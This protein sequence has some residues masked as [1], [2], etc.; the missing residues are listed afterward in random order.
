MAMDFETAMTKVRTLASESEDNIG[1]LKQGILDLAPAVGIGPTALAEGLL[2]IES[3][4]FRGAA[5]MDILTMSAQASAVGL[6]DTSAVARA[7]TAAIN[8]YGIENLSA[9]QA[10]DVL[11]ATVDAGGAEASELAGELGRVVGIASQ[12][13]ISFQEVGAFIATYTRLGLSA[14]EATTGLSGVMNTILSPSKEARDALAGVGL[15]AQALR[16]A[17]QEQGLAGALAMLTDRLG[18]NAEATAAVFGNVRALAGVMG[19]AGSQ[20][21]TYSSILAQ[22]G[23]SAGILNERF[24][25]WRTTTAATWKEFTAQAQVAAIQIGERLA[26]AFSKVLQAAAP[27]LDAFIKLVEW[28]GQLPQ[29]VQTV[30]IGFLGLAAAIGPVAWAIGTIM[31]AGSGFVGLL[32]TIGIVGPVAGAGASVAAGGI[33][34]LWLALAPLAAPAAIVGGILAIGMAI[35]K[36]VDVMTSAETDKSVRDFALANFDASHGLPSMDMPRVDAPGLFRGGTALGPLNV[37]SKDGMVNGG[38]LPAAL[39]GG[40]GSGAA[41]QISAFEQSVRS[42]VDRLGGSDVVNAA[43][44]W[45]A[46]L[47]RIGGVIRL[48]TDEFTAYT[49]AISTAVEKMRLMGQE[50]PRLWAIIASTV[51]N[52]KMLQEQRDFIGQSLGGGFEMN[53][54]QLLLASS[55]GNLAGLMNAVPGAMASQ[56]ASAGV[57]AGISFG[58]QYIDG[59]KSTLQ[60]QLG[61]TMLAAFTGG[62]N[63]GKSIG[64]LLGGELI[65]GLAGKL[66]SSLSGMFGKT[67]GGALGSVI[68]GL[69][70]MLGSM[71]GPLIGKLASKIWGGIQGVFG[72]DEEARDVNPA[73]DAFLAQFG[74][75]GTGLGSGFHNL[76]AKLTE[77]T[78]EAGGG[79]L[80]QA[81]T[82]SD[83]MP[84]LSAAMAAIEQ[85]LA[86]TT[87]TATTGFDMANDATQ[88]FTMSLTGSD[89]AIKELGATQVTVTEMM[90]T[91]FDR[92]LDKLNELIARLGVAGGAMQ[93]LSGLPGLPTAGTPGEHVGDASGFEASLPGWSAPELPEVIGDPSGAPR[94]ATTI[95]INAGTIIGNPDELAAMVLESIEGGGDNYSHARTLGMVQ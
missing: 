16:E 57:P 43:R 23:T 32:R 89:E 45:D 3:T 94:N 29:P 7:L 75:E 26:P 13:G 54:Q 73:R 60:T 39:S 48:T 14:A 42:L 81:L 71:I 15:S 82:Q 49:Q 68:P 52:N 44:S 76:A 12:L 33:G 4:G 5:A 85:K 78:G 36:L 8:A 30:A 69:G 65:G 34:R 56:N 10:A 70:T 58:Q 84:E 74:G 24:A 27:V 1:R 35:G 41:A 6:G 19:T 92:L 9:A 2:V 67:I 64:G 22:I 11:F 83:T 46:A 61:P 21:Q 17:V 88:T 28:F 72:T 90:L 91:G 38:G 80:F 51:A 95:Q 50:V 62:G 77:L 31:S 79:A 25:I 20:A 93:A 55:Q 53:R 18:G 37:P 66:T 86:A 40:G 47:R 63:V 59:F 87:T